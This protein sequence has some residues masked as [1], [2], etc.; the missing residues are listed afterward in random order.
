MFCAHLESK[1]VVAEVHQVHQN[2]SL[3]ASHW[4]PSSQQKLMFLKKSAIHVRAGW[5]TPLLLCQCRS[6]VPSTW[7][8]SHSRSSS[9]A[10]RTRSR[11]WRRS[12]SVF[13]LTGASLNCPYGSESPVT[14]PVLF[15]WTF[16]AKWSDWSEFVTLGARWSGLVLGATSEWAIV[17]ILYIGIWSDPIIYMYMYVFKCLHQSNLSAFMVQLPWMG[18]DWSFRAWGPAFEDGG[19]G[20]LVRCPWCW[21]EYSALRTS[22]WMLSEICFCIQKKNYITSLKKQVWFVQIVVT[23]CSLTPQGLFSRWHSSECMS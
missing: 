8:L 16:E 19:W 22:T 3:D 11:E 13:T 20:V 21:V 10:T 7:R 4:P 23:L 12:D 6:P 1:E 15:R 18:R 17:N 5:W 9:R 2:A 14:L